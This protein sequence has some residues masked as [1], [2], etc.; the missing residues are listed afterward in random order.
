MG[1]GCLGCAG[2][3]GRGGGRAVSRVSRR[4]GGQRDRGLVK[5]GSADV[6]RN[7]VASRAAGTGAKH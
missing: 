6:G 5:A 7:S 2:C 1:E 4:P 3:G